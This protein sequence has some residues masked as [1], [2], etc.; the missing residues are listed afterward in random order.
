MAHSSRA[1]SIMV[2]EGMV[3]LPGLRQSFLLLHNQ[4]VEMNAGVQLTIS[5][6]VILGPLLSAASVLAASTVPQHP[7]NHV[8]SPAG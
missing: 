8:V 5:C 4:E 7:Q 3:W 2:R 6:L 1:Q